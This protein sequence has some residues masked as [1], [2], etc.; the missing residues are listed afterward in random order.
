MIGDGYT[1]EGRCLGAA[2]ESF[3]GLRSVRGNRVKVKVGVSL[4]HESNSSRT[5]L[6][7][8]VRRVP[9]VGLCSEGRHRAP[10]SR[11]RLR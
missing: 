11:L 8:P 10:S 7:P 4:G 2:N 1:V 5:R 6:Q 3:D 9:S